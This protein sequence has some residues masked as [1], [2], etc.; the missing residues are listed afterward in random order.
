[1]S[2]IYRFD[3]EALFKD[4]VS[5]YGLNLFLGAGFSTYAYNDQQETLPLGGEIATRLC[6]LFNLDKTV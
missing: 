4:F 3:N 6:S 1:M 2:K 5:K